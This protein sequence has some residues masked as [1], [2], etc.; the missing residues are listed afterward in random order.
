M[1]TRKA[2]LVDMLR[3]HGFSC[4]D[5]DALVSGLKDEMVA[6]SKRKSQRSIVGLFGGVIATGLAIYRLTAMLTI[7]IGAIEP[8]TPQ[9]KTASTASMTS[10]TRS[11]AKSTGSP[12][13]WART[14][15][16]PANV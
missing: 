16:V 12:T 6:A 14:K 7:F 11:A 5:A 3:A 13:R 8:S 15:S 2:L 10:S 4:L 1:K 9:S